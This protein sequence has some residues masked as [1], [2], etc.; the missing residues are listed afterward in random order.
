MHS[1]GYGRNLPWPIV[2]YDN[3]MWS[4]DVFICTE[5]FSHC[6]WHGDCAAYYLHPIC[7]ALKINGTGFIRRLLDK[8]A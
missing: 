4:N 1:K 5:A 7:A 2:R 3:E 6:K 8:G